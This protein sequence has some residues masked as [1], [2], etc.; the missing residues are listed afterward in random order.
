MGVSL[1]PSTTSPHSA[2][3]AATRPVS[4]CGPAPVSVQAIGSSPWRHRA[5]P[6]CRGAAHRVRRSPCGGRARPASATWRYRDRAARRRDRAA[7]AGRG[8]AR[9]R[10]GRS[11]RGF[12]SSD[13]SAPARRGAPARRRKRRGAADWRRTGSS[14]ASP[15]QCR[16]SNMA[17]SYSGRQRVASMSSM[18]SRNRPPARRA[19]SALSAAE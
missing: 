13:R 17:A 6:P 9:R 18:R 1:R 2:G 4:P 8:R 11:R 7:R 14:Q 3:L 19:M 15:S 10:G 12:R 16:S 5:P